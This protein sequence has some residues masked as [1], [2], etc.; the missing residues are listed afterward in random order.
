MTRP[1]SYTLERRQWVPR[2]LAATF[3]FFDRPENLARITPPWLGFELLTPGPIVMARGLTLDHRVRLCG[4]PMRWR[5]LIREY[6]PPYR[7]QDVQLVGPYRRWEHTH[8]FRAEGSGTLVEDLV[9]YEPPLG[10]LGALANALFIRGR[11]VA[12]FDY[13]R[14]AIDALLVAAARGEGAA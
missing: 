6:D 3:A 11:L 14:A 9:V 2:P 5:S 1:R 10:P 4:V 12:I 8:R 13:R 7:F